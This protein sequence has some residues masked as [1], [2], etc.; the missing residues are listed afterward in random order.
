MSIATI[1][2]KVGV[3]AVACIGLSLTT[4][5]SAGAAELD[6]AESAVHDSAQSCGYDGYVNGQATY[7]H[8]GH[9]SVVIRVHHFFW[10]TTYACMPRGT[11]VIPRGTVVWA[12][13]SAEYDGHACI[14]DYPIAPIAVVGP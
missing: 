4:A 8:C 1:L 6:R 9:G 12:I 13:T 11:Y 2:A 5:G 10:Q 14:Y 3:I 7:N